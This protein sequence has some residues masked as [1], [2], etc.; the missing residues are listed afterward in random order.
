VLGK[1]ATDPVY[2]AVAGALQGT[3]HP[4]LDLGSG[5]GLLAFYLRES[6]FEQPITGVDHDAQKVSAAI[7]ASGAGEGLRFRVQDVREVADTGSNIMA[8]DLLHYFTPEEQSKLLLYIASAVPPGGAAVIRD[9]IRDSSWRYR[10]TYLQESFSR[11]VRWL[12]AERLNFPTRESIVQPFRERGF[13]VEV[14]PLSGAFPFN[15][16]L[17]VFR[18]PS[19]GMTNS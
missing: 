2:R 1:V 14:R 4:L 13:E 3:T 19:S 5:I 6:G 18:R 10:L 9:C 16:Y 7:A 17:F 8:L 12:K 15:N 11:A